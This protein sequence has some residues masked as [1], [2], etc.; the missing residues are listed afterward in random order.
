[1]NQ[2]VKT[3]PSMQECVEERQK[4]RHQP[5]SQPQ[6][7]SPTSLAKLGLAESDFYAELEKA[8]P[9]ENTQNHPN[10]DQNISAVLYKL[11]SVLYKYT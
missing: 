11:S 5:A 7:H 8:V 6:A 1:M 9:Y 10:R 3:N 2:K 4:I